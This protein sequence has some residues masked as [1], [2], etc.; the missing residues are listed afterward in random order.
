LRC[1]YDRLFKSAFPEGTK[2]EPKSHLEDLNPDS[3]LVVPKAYTNRHIKALSVGDRIQFEREAYFAVDKDS[4]PE[5][6]VFNRIV[7][8]KE[9]K[10]KDD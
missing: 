2:L 9:D 1:A 10:H 4:T 5:K 7:S 8:L 3:L 6:M